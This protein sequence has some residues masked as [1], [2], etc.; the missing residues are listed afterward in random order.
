MAYEKQKIHGNMNVSGSFTIGG[1]EVRAATL[2]D[3]KTSV[4]TPYTSLFNFL[5]GD[6]TLP[7]TIAITTGAAQGVLQNGAAVLFTT[8]G[9]LPLAA[10]FNATSFTATGSGFAYNRYYVINASPTT[11]QLSTE[12]NG[13]AI[14]FTNTGTGIHTCYNEQSLLAGW[15]CCRGHS[16]GLSGASYMGTAYKS[17]FDVLWNLAGIS[18]TDATQPLTLWKPNPS[19]PPN[20][21]IAGSKGATSTAD[22]AAGYAIVLQFEDYF[23]R[24]QN[25][26]RGLLSSQTDA[27]QDHKHDYY[28][29]TSTYDTGTF[30]SSDQMAKTTT[31]SRNLASTTSGAALDIINNPVQNNSMGVPRVASETRSKNIA[32]N[33]YIKF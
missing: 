24:S 1:I 28:M 31:A 12:P 30:T 18:A 17:L 6:V 23:V 26:T 15:I 11:F 27:F 9:A 10:G 32:M 8:T 4:L 14:T 13:T 21:I 22:W 7:S 33:F 25:G 20:Y 29:D 3:V 19:A 5:P 16:I 2:G